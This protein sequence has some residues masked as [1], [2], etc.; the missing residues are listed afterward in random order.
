MV[1][2]PFT[3]KLTSMLIGQGA[4]TLDDPQ[5]VG[6][7]ILVMLLFHGNANE[8]REGFQIFYRSTI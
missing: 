5:Q 3:L 7:C 8:T 2:L 6:I 4:L 1:K